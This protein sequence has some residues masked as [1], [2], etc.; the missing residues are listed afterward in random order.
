VLNTML[1]KKCKS[2]NLKLDEKEERRKGNK[3]EEG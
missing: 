3:K 1:K 2:K